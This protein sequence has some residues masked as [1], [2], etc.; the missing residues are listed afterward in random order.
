MHTALVSAGTSTGSGFSVTNLLVVLA[1]FVIGWPLFRRFRR[2]VSESRKWRWVE[3][4][5]M[6][7]PS[8]GPTDERA[9]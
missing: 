8:N 6:D 3:E 4:G 1:L 2:S 7:P 5:L 9:E